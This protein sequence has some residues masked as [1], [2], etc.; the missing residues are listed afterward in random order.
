MVSAPF[1]PNVE[2]AVPPKDAEL[3]AAFVAMSEGVVIV[4]AAL[5]VVV[6]VAPKE[7]RPKKL[8]ELPK[9]EAPRTVSAGVVR[10]PVEEKVEVAVAPKD[11]WEA[12]AANF[13]KRNDVVAFVRVAAPFA[14]KL[15]ESVSE[16]KAAIAAKRLVEDAVVA[17]RAVEVAAVPVAFA[18]VKL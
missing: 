18:N 9:E 4:P 10:A 16:P 15:P 2:V 11:A 3:T 17:K 6:P 14:V 7:E 8:A 1:V 12:D 5:I 13:T